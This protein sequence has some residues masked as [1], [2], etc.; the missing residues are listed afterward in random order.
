[1]Q[2]KSGPL[3]G[4]SFTEWLW[5]L[6]FSDEVS[7]KYQLNVATGLSSPT[8]TLSRTS[9][10]AL[11]GRQF[12]SQLEGTEKKEKKLP[13]MTICLVLAQFSSLWRA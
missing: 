1:M 2:R 11:P 3:G 5:Q 10:S 7:S 12:F 9:W 6:T 4:L 8:V 13:F